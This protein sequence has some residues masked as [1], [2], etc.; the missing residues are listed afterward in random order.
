[1]LWKWCTTILNGTFH[2]GHLKFLQSVNQ[3]V[4]PYQINCKQPLW[5]V[6]QM[7]L[8]VNYELC[9]STLHYFKLSLQAKLLSFVWKV[10]KW[11]SITSWEIFSEELFHAVR[12]S[13]SD[14]FSFNQME[15]SS[16]TYT[17][18]RFFGRPSLLIN[19]FRLLISTFSV[20]SP[21]RLWL[22]IMNNAIQWRR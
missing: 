21:W 5:F 1:M 22:S 19:N 4:F 13:E 16:F 3:T 17:A 18:Y 11:H 12:F 15:T 7:S 2:W 20:T 9:R 6:R 10:F 14:S 8:F